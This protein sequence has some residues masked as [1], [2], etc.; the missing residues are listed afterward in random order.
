LR[1][2]QYTYWSL[3]IGSARSRRPSS[4]NGTESPPHV[5]LDC[6]DL[7][8]PGLIHTL[9]VTCSA[10]IRRSPFPFNGCDNAISCTS[11]ASAVRPASPKPRT[12]RYSKG[13]PPNSAQYTP[14]WKHAGLFATDNSQSRTCRFQLNVSYS[15]PDI[16]GNAQSGFY[17]CS[18]VL[19]PAYCR[20][21]EH[22]LGCLLGE[23]SHLPLLILQGDYRI[24]R[25]HDFLSLSRRCHPI[26]L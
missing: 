23:C 21:R 2:K 22:V 20:G 15:W 17:M 1:G 24:P 14:C 18:G 4:Y 5:P 9:S 7:G 6:R 16:S 12:L 13:S 11:L 8:T 10:R 26:F 25:R 3:Y 19:G